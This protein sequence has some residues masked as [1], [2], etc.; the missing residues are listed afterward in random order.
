MAML[1]KGVQCGCEREFWQNAL[2]ALLKSVALPAGQIFIK[3]CGSQ[4]NCSIAPET[5]LASIRFNSESPDIL[6]IQTQDC[7][8]DII[9]IRLIAK[10]EQRESVTFKSLLTASLRFV[11][12]SRPDDKT[13]ENVEGVPLESLL[14][15]LPMGT[16]LFDRQGQVLQTNGKACELL[17]VS[18][19]LPS[20]GK[21]LWEFIPSALRDAILAL[22]REVLIYSTDAHKEFSVPDTSGNLRRVEVFVSGL[23]DSA[24]PNY[25]LL[26]LLDASV[27]QEVDDLKKLDQLK[28]NFMAMI[29]HELRTPLTSI[30]GATHL[31]HSHLPAASDSSDFSLIGI[32]QTNTERLIRLVNNLLD[33]VTIENNSLALMPRPENVCELIT[34]VLEKFEPLAK[35]K[36]QT[37]ESRCDH[38]EWE[39]DSERFKQLIAHLVDNAVKFTPPGGRISVALKRDGDRMEVCVSDTGCGIPVHARE[40]VFSRFYQV[41]DPMTR[42]IG[43]AGIGLYL[44]GNI[45]ELHGGRIK[46]QGNADCGSD[47][48]V[49]FNRQGQLSSSLESP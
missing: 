19:D 49:I 4:G 45:A 46:V 25:F 29:S 7:R 48:I 20:H 33:M 27:R 18:S 3:R 17:G 44:A 24:S 28:S 26:T 31:L 35:A 12:C 13:L 38:V 41:Q 9:G 5:V 23:G 10:P 40:E 16:L 21:T 43:G 22:Q 1:E 47:F 15:S 32:V 8:Q 30:R 42:C 39:V 36:F 37:L 2:E 6:T 34:Q 14:D 11:S